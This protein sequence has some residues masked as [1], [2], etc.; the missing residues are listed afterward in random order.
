MPLN[1]KMHFVNKYMELKKKIV[2][3]SILYFISTS[4]NRKVPPPSKYRQSKEDT[5]GEINSLFVLQT[6]ANFSTRHQFLGLRRPQVW[7]RTRRL[8]PYT[9]ITCSNPCSSDWTFPLISP[10]I[11]T[12]YLLM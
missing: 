4:S 9:I 12:P 11:L 2:V 10:S 7:T 6:L 8:R 5:R 3:C 1:I